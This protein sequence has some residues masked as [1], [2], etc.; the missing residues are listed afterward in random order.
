MRKQDLVQKI[1]CYCGESQ[2]YITQLEAVR[3][4]MGN[5]SYQNP[6]L[7]NKLIISK[8]QIIAKIFSFDTSSNLFSN[9]LIKITDEI[10]GK[11]CNQPDI[12]KGISDKNVLSMIKK[13]I[14]RDSNDYITLQS[15]GDLYFGEHWYSALEHNDNR[16]IRK[17]VIIKALSDFKEELWFSDV[18][19][20][21]DKNYNDDWS[22]WKVTQTSGKPY[23][24]CP[25]CGYNLGC[26]CGN[27]DRAPEPRK[28]I[29]NIHVEK[30][31]I[32]FTHLNDVDTIST[33]EHSEV[34]SHSHYMK[35]PLVKKLQCLNLDNEITLYN[36]ELPYR[37][38]Y[39]DKDKIIAIQSF[40]CFFSA[41]YIMGYRINDKSFNGGTCDLHIVSLKK[42]GSC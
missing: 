35:D 36:C 41:L 24:V 17:D 7:D 11:K 10:L 31:C 12:G 39:F 34:D 20:M 42:E 5:E 2:P 26:G 37:N 1:A 30:K 27:H 23:Q 13:I 6:K 4:C 22:T 9:E 3:L 14:D 21:F 38:D 29:R 32:R 40:G 18:K 15:L 28:T 8:A 25:N 33:M 16:V 19:T